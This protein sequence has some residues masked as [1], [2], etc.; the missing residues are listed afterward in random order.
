M[1]TYLSRLRTRSRSSAS[2]PKYRA[3]PPGRRIDVRG[4]PHGETVLRYKLGTGRRT[5]VTLLRL[6]REAA[7]VTAGMLLAR[8][9]M[10]LRELL[11]GKPKEA[12]R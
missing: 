2:L 8:Y 1:M 3:T 12:G 10:D 5:K 7:C 6:S 9:G 11:A 4:L